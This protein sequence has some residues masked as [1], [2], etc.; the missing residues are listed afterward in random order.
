ME[1]FRVVWFFLVWVFVRICEFIYKVSSRSSIYDCRV[2]IKSLVRGF[3]R[4]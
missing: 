3:F 2:I 1:F 4:C